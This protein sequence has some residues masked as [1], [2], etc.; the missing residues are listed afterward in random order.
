M[1]TR[2]LFITLTATLFWLQ[3]TQAYCVYNYLDNENS[4]VYVEE[5]S[6]NKE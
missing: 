5:E 2:L 4:S 3:L 6:V 1:T